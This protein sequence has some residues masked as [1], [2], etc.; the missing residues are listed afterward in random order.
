MLGVMDMFP[1]L[2]VFMVSAEYMYIETHPNGY[3][4]MYCLLCVNRITIKLLKRKGNKNILTK[5]KANWIMSPYLTPCSGFPVL[6]VQNP[7]YNG[8]WKAILTRPC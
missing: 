4:H 5:Q 8:I 6:S 7:V 2:M 3:L 1:L